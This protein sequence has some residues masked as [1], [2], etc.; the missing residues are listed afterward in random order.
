VLLWDNR[1]TQHYAANDY[2]PHRR[3]MHRVMVAEDHRANDPAD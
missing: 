3:V 1:E 2:L